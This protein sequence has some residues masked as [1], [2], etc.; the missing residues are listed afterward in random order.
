M[1]VPLML[2]A[3]WTSCALAVGALGVHALVRHSLRATRLIWGVAIILAVVLVAIAPL[4]QLERPADN[5]ESLDA[6]G[7][8][9]AIAASPELIA[10]LL[11]RYAPG[12]ASPTLAGLWLLSSLVVSA[13]FGLT[14]RRH[15]RRVGASDFATIDGEQVA[16]SDS[17]GPAVVGIMNPRIVVPRWLLARP[18]VDQRLVVEHERSHVRARDPLALLGGCLAVAAMPWNPAIWFMLSRLRL[19][20]E[21]DCDA[22]LLAAG[23]PAPAYGALLIDLTMLVPRTGVGAPAFTCRP[24][25]LER[26]LLAMTAR[27]L[28]FLGARIATATTVAALALAVACSSELPTAGQVDTMDVRA[29]EARLAKIAPPSADAVRYVVDGKVVSREEAEAIAPSRI[30]SISVQKNAVPSEIRVTTTAPGVAQSTDGTTRSPGTTAAAG[31]T[32]S[33]VMEQR[34]PATPARK[35]FTGLLFVDGVATDAKEMQTIS[36]DRI[37]SVEVV[38][39]E[40]A[41]REYGA[42]GANGVIRITTK[43]A[44]SAAS[45]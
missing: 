13:A 12:W 23:A 44:P 2:Y 5:G 10:A 18:A 27:P 6:G 33:G 41:A 39:G 30:A 22:R 21:L 1:L 40:A 20:I 15:R 9:T 35:E 34:T 38:K 7:G 26:R 29:A 43:K 28:S 19:S 25:H 31:L 8:V 16:V 3:L 11:G 17:L 36:P 24:S 37:A 4:R 14:W 42:A 32:F 45:P